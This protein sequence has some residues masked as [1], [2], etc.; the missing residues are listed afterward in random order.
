LDYGF[1]TDKAGLCYLKSG[2][3][4]ARNARNVRNLTELT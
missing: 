2:Q 1:E 4:N 3:R